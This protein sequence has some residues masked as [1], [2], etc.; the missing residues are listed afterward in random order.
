[1]SDAPKANIL[2][3]DNDAHLA[4]ELLVYLQKLGYQGIAAHGSRE[5]LI[6]FRKGEFHLVITDL[7]MPEIDG[8]QLLEIIKTMDQQVIVV[9]ISGFGTFNGALEALKKGAFDFIPKPFKLQQLKA[10]VAKALKQHP[11][12][13][14]S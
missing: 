5:A 8:M 10:I 11:A 13:K 3:V 14:N 12:F 6:K 7:K 2:V 4:D 9:V 1:M